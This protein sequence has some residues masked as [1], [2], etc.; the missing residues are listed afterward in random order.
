MILKMV[1]F[2]SD[3]WGS[4]VSVVG[5][6]LTI[7]TLV[8]A[9]GA[10]AAAEEARAIARKR[11]LV[12]DLEDAASRMRQVGGWVRDGKWELVQLRA[13]EVLGVCKSVMSR[14][15]DHL[16]ESADKLRSATTLLSSIAKRT[17]DSSLRELDPKER[18]QIFDAQLRADE[19]ISEAMG[20]ARR[21]EERK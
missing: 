15:G 5:V 12:E 14:W 2:V 10:K 20:H 9:R 11:D 8:S 7:W 18:R 21:G 19:L 6:L 17:M 1:Q 13:Q 3:N 4:M 16:E